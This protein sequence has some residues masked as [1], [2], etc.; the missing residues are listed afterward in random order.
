MKTE[1]SDR[2]DGDGCLYSLDW[3]TGLTQTAIKC[4]FQCRTEAHSAC[5]LLGVFPQVSRGQRSHAYFNEHL[6]SADMP[7][8]PHLEGQTHIFASQP[9]SLAENLN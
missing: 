2:L 8:D 1:P 5:T 6:F 3:T 9:A 7:R 4:P